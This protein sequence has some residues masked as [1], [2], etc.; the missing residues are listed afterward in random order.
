MSNYVKFAAIGPKTAAAVTD[1]G[2]R[3]DYIPEVFSAKELA[4][5]LPQPGRTLLFR[6]EDG[7]KELAAI[8]RERGFSVDDIAAYGTIRENSCPA[9]VRESLLRGDF[10]CVTFTSASTVQGF[11]GSLKGLDCS[12]ITA[13][14]IGAETASEALKH[15]FR[16][17]VSKSATI[18][19]MIEKI[20][21]E[22][23]K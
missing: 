18:E 17:V 13:L 19:S 11:T 14:C 21:E 23:K 16:I 22:L 7:A 1:K 6:A 12:G 15:G 3:V 10:A 2:M 5:G 9:H 4:A 8:L 20:R